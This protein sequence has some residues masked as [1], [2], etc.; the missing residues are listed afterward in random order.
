MWA[1]LRSAWLA[2]F[3]I[4]NYI[5][6]HVNAAWINPTLLSWRR[7]HQWIARVD[8]IVYPISYIDVCIYMYM[9]YIYIYNYLSI[10]LSTYLSTYLP[11]Y[12]ST[13]LPI[14]L[15]IYLSTYL[16]I[17]L[18]I[19]LSIYPSIYL[20]IHLS[21]YLFIY[22]SIYLYIYMCVCLI[23][24]YLYIYIP[25]LNPQSPTLFT[26]KSLS[27]CHILRTTQIRCAAGANPCDRNQHPGIF[28]PKKMV[29]KQE[30][31]LQREEM[32]QP[33]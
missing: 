8:I 30:I 24:S 3:Q 17:Y 9:G 22:L 12:L 32:S 5:P 16:S 13:Y 6:I 14:Y 33:N 20:S 29:A 25:Q 4:P 31:D 7:N 10:Y 19:Y 11:T 2:K 28:A 26:Q 27:Q 18:T 21:I 15:S 23:Y 1:L